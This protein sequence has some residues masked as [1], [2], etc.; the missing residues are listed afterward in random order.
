M[1]IPKAIIS[2][3][4]GTL[5]DTMHLIRHG[6][7]ETIRTY[8]TQLGVDDDRIP[9]YATY[10]DVLHE[11]L[12]GSAHDTLRRT[13]QQLYQDDS[14]LLQTIDYDTLH[15]LLNPTQDKIAPEFVRAYTGL[16]AFL[17]EL[18]NAKIKFAIFT[19]GTPHHVV[20]NF[21][22]ALPEVGLQELFLD[23]TKSDREKLG[24]FEDYMTNYFDLPAF[25]VVT[26]EDV[27]THKP[28]PDS[29]NLAMQRLG[30]SPAESAVLGDHKVDM[31]SGVNAN[32][33]VRIGL[34][35]GFGDRAS[36]NEAGATFII[37][38]L[39]ELTEKLKNNS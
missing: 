5:I 21:G 25:T 31:L 34:T 14:A 20:R 36:L 38:S 26:C 27:T 8:L 18:G 9:E 1:E 16:P 3:A 15:D 37:D 12:G 32:V 29:L 11:T 13:I 35:H 24:I 39:N 23:K 28:N 4:D 17:V 10:E 30:V 7:Y 6:Q 33:P 22:V 2:D 19:S